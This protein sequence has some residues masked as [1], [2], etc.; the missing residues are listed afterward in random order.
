LRTRIGALAAFAVS[1]AFLAPQ[2]ASAATEFGD[3]CPAVTG[4]PGPNT[5]TTLSAPA[6]AIPLTAPS[7]G[8]VTK[9][10]VN[11]GVTLPYSVPFSVKLL[12]SAGGNSYTTIDQA[13]VNAGTGVTVADARMAAQAGDR[14]GLFGPPFAVE[15]TPIPGIVL[16]CA[17]P[18]IE[19]VLGAV[20]GSD[21]PPGSTATYKEVTTGRVPLAAVIEPDAD[22]DGFGDE[23]QD[24]CPQSASTQVEC[25]V[26]V[27]DSF[28]LAKKSSIVVLVAAS[29]TGSVSV[30]GSA[31]LPKAS[32]ASASAQAKLKKVTKN[33]TAGKLARFTLRFP[34][35]LKAALRALPRGKKITVKLQATATNVAG[36]VSR[37]KAKLKLK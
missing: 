32:K 3:T 24:K 29:E 2:A 21:V 23:T 17:G 18:G 28:P 11:S 22:G 9:V 12:R 34:G 6:G 25:P 19:G 1:A 16:F 8:V 37:D 31:K 30:S 7:S 5:L 4:A 26:I 36:Q 10:K 33:V 13:T 15:G 14:L 35:N 20:A 27:L